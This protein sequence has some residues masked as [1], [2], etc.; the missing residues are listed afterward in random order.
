MTSDFI[1]LLAHC[2]RLWPG[3]AIE[4]LQHH[5]IYNGLIQ[6]GDKK[7]N[8]DGCYIYVTVSTVSS[9]RRDTY[10]SYSRSSRL[11]HLLL[12][13]N[14][15]IEPVVIHM[16]RHSIPHD[17]RQRQLVSTTRE[18]GDTTRVTQNEQGGYRQ[19]GL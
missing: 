3:G 19:R 11:A 10:E 4:Q 1:V 13:C 12:H 7:C 18:L 15:R 8:V 6:R 2:V 17:D 5:T 9:P 14:G 16:H